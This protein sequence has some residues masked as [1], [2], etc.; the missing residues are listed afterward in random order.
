MKVLATVLVLTSVAST[1]SASSIKVACDGE[2]WV[3]EWTSDC[4]SFYE[5]NV[6]ALDTCA[7]H[8][9]RTDWNEQWT[10]S[11][12]FYLQTIFKT[13]ADCS[14]SAD[15]TH[16]FTVGVCQEKL[17]VNTMGL[18]ISKKKVVTYS[19]SSKDDCSSPTTKVFFD[20]TDCQ[21]N[22]KNKFTCSTDLKTFTWG[23]WTGSACSG[24]AAMEQ[25]DKEV[26]KCVKTSV[27]ALKSDSESGGNSLKAQTRVGLLPALLVASLS[28]LL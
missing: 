9:Q 22:G 15:E 1:C 28:A 10:K 4:S 7:P 11:G 20:S 21:N 8:K 14:G 6:F 12:N 27:D 2:K 3:Q 23:Q 16:N 25:K 18:K 13:S 24:T 19:S 26:G 5:P 17:Y